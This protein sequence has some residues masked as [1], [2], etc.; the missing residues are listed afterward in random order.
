MSNTIDLLKYGSGI[1]VGKLAKGC[2]I[3]GESVEIRDIFCAHEPVVCDKCKAAVM[4]I[5][6]NEED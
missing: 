3:C 4:K 1:A 5:R 2:L 6:N